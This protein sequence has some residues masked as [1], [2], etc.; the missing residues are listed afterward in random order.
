MAFLQDR[1]ALPCGLAIFF[2]YPIPIGAGK[3]SKKD[4]QQRTRPSLGCGRQEMI[5]LIGL[6]DDV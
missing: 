2:A 3:C 5:E 1:S 4:K 6:D